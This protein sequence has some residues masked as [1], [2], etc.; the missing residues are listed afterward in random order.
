M[1]TPLGYLGEEFAIYTMELKEFIKDTISQI[2]D[3]VDELNEEYK[4]KK[5][6][7]NPYSWFSIRDV[8]QVRS[9]DKFYNLTNIDFDLDVV[10]E[11]LENSKGNVGVLAGILKAGGSMEEGKNNKASNKVHFTIPVMLPSRKAYTENPK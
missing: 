9:G 11:N 4:D 2:V 10:V 7:V 8:T 3:A 1:V 5:I 6:V